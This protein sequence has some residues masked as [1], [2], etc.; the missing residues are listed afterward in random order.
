MIGFNE[1]VEQVESS[2]TFKQ[3]RERYPEA[4]LC[5][6]FFIRDYASGEHVNTIDYKVQKKVFTFSINKEQDLAMQEDELID[7]PGKNQL[8][9]INSPI[10]ID[11]FDVEEIVEK[12][13]EEYGV[14]SELQKIIA[15]MH[16]YTGKETQNKEEQIWN[17]TCMLQQLEI[18]MILIH[19]TTG[20]VLKVEKKNI[21][22]FIKKD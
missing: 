14:A 8:K 1:L 18:T 22:Q 20:N 5:A 13:L 11:L 7:A 10:N 21:L 2:G 19:A 9:K 6:G 3:F 15:I 16:M 17:V 12:T 4:E